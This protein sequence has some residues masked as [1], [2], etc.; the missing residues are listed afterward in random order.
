M[1]LRKVSPK[2]RSFCQIDIDI[3]DANSTTSLFTDSPTAFAEWKRDRRRVVGFFGYRSIDSSSGSKKRSKYDTT[4]V[5]SGSGPYS[6]VSDR[7]MFIHRRYLE[8]LPTKP[9]SSSSSCCHL[10]LSMQVV[11]ASSRAP[12]VVRSKPR[13]LLDGRTYTSN[14]AVSTHRL[15][16]SVPNTDNECS[17]A[18]VPKWLRPSDSTQLREEGNSI[19]A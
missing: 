9:E 11:A 19:L 4:M 15:G 8:V 12:L 5:P 10:L 1:N 18:C 2:R 17:N 13:E 7:A 3:V 14:P 6:M 16:Q